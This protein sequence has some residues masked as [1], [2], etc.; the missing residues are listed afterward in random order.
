MR[1]EEKER[2]AEFHHT[3]SEQLNS[4][5]SESPKFF[6]LLVVVGTA[7]AYVLSNEQLSS[8]QSSDLTTLATWLCLAV[9]LWAGWYLAALGYAFR[10]LQRC[11]HQIEDGLGW[12]Q[13]SPES[14]EIPTNVWNPL[15]WFWLLPGIYHPHALG[16]AVFL[17]FVSF[18]G[19]HSSCAKWSAAVV[20][21]IAMGLMNLRYL[22][23]FKGKLKP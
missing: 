15:N 2:L 7:Y 18:E 10:F 19:L 17:V 14:G 11:Q 13:F 1:E 5:L 16:L 23:K 8:K 6:A 3:I 21:V 12:R 9:A 22:L 20:G 4:R